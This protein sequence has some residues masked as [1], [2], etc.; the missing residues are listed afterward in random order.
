MTLVKCKQCYGTKK[1][2]GLGGMNKDCDKCSAGYV[3]SSSI[4]IVAALVNEAALVVKKKAGRPVG[5][6]KIKS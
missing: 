4:S 3:D 1:Y 2:K 6:R 5:Y